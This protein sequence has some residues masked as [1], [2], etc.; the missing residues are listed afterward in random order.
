[1]SI[2]VEEKHGIK[3]EKAGEGYRITLRGE[4]HTMGNLLVEVLSRMS[5]VKAAQY[6]NP[7]PL[8]EEIILYLQLADPNADPVEVLI[9]ALEKI[10]EEADRFMEELK[11]ALEEKGVDTDSLEA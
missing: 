6:R 10:Q 11:K 8:E 7:H 2:Y 1:M 5:E 4:D 3:I 9:R